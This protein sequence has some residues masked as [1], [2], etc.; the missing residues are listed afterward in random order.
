M[1]DAAADRQTVIARAVQQRPR[2]S[3]GWLDVLCLTAVALANPAVYKLHMS[4]LPFS[5][6]NIAYLTLAR[7]FLSGFSLHL[8]AWGHVDKG[9]ILPPLYPLL[10]ALGSPFTDEPFALAERISGMSLILAGIP[11]YF[12]V[13]T[14]TSRLVATCSVIAIQLNRQYFT[15]AFSGLTEPL[16]LLMTSCALLALQRSL[17]RNHWVHAFG[18]G[19]LCA[20]VYLSRQIGLI[21]LLFSLAWTALLPLCQRISGRL[22]LGRMMLI[23]G[24]FTTILAPYA[25]LVY[26]QTG[27]HPFRQ[28]FRWGTYVVSSDDPDVLAEIDR[29]KV[30]QFERP[31]QRLK[32]RRETYK[33]LPDGSEMYAHLYRE[34]DGDDSPIATILEGFRQNPLLL[35]TNLGRNL[36]H[37]NQSLGFLI[38]GALF[39]VLSW[40]P[41]FG[42]AE[43]FSRRG[44][45]AMFVWFYLGAISLSTG[46]IPRYVHVMLPFVVLHVA[47]EAYAVA[48]ASPLGVRGGWLAVL[49][50]VL[51]TG[52]MPAH[53]DKL[54]VVEKRSLSDQPH[55][56]LRERVEEGEPVFSLHAFDSYIVGGSHR[57]LPNDELERVVEYGRRTGVRWI[58]VAQSPRHRQEILRYANATWYTDR[59]LH[60]SH[61]DLVD[62]CCEV[63]DEGYRYALYRIRP[64]PSRAELRIGD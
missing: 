23:L 35:V 56:A 60:E 7:D 26:E 13:R 18:L 2:L 50:L 37:L 64:T 6:D 27:Q 55:W 3:G 46:A 51:G 8:P 19:L 22:V 32:L 63:K 58:L 15:F 12:L 43:T 11:L 29:I 17:I 33:L 59:R 57:V 42:P 54:R 4:S 20:L 1:R 41:F 21:V 44:M 34:A 25:L 40:T 61:P 48:R 30:M 53:F 62:L 38:F 47:S 24:G 52:L 36:R 45:L 39:L 5:S 16:F 49:L 10:I 14:R 9:I 31:L 28:A